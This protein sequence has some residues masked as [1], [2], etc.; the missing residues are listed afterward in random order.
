[1]FLNCLLGNKLLLKG[2]LFSFFS[3]FNQGASFLLLII[4]A[5]YIA[6]SDYG[7]LSLFNTIISFLG[8]VVSLST[9]G[10]ITISFFKKDEKKFKQ[11][12]TLIFL[13][14]FAVATFFAF[15]LLFFTSTSPGHSDP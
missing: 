1:M 7:T 5:N 2:A 11:D 12:Y 4:L 15:L 10:Y 3:F 13:I 14:T 6:P 9:H 8:F